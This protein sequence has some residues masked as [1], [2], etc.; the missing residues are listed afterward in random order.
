MKIIKIWF[1]ILII[2]FSISYSF[3]LSY[4]LKEISKPWCRFLSWA[5]HNQ[6]C[7]IELP[8]IEN[9]DYKK[10]IN[11]INYRIIYSVL[12]TSTY[13]NWWDVWY[14]SHIWVD[15][16]SAKWTP[17]YSIFDWEIVVAKNLAWRWNTVVIKHF[18]NWKYIYSVYAH[19]SKIEINLWD[20]I[21]EWEKIGEIWSTWNSIWN[22]LHFQIDINDIWSHPYYYSSCKW[23]VESVVNS[24]ECKQLVEKNTIDPILF[25]ESNWKF[26]SESNN[27]SQ[28]ILDEK[29]INP[30]DIK[31]KRQD[32]EKAET[33][34][35]LKLYKINL[36]SF[37]PQ[38][39][40]NPNEIWYIWVSFYDNIKKKE[41][42]WV[43][44]SYLE[45]EFDSWQVDIFPQKIKLIENWIRKIKI[46]AKKTW[47]SSINFK[48][49]WITVLKYNLII[50]DN[51][52]N[53]QAS[54][55]NLQ[56]FW[57]NIVWTDNIWIWIMKDWLNFN[58][59]WIKYW[60]DF[61]IEVNWEAQICILRITKKSQLKNLSKL[62]CSKNKYWKELY[63]NY[64]DTYK[65]ILFFK[66][67]FKSKNDIEFKLYNTKNNRLLFTKKISWISYPLDLLSNDPYYKYII[68]S[69]EWWYI[70]NFKK[71]YFAPNFD[72]EKKDFEKLIKINYNKTVSIKSKYITRLEFIKKLYEIDEK[73]N[74]KYDWKWFKDINDSDKK[75][76][77][78]LLKNNIK[79]LDNYWERYFQ[80][81]KNITRKEVAYLIY[82]L[83]KK[84]KNN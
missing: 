68:Q 61:K 73:L 19:L 49:L 33:E 30:I 57:S 38:N 69:L 8:R 46:T 15:I 66:Y 21:K 50:K 7:I 35:F 40:I 13:E 36:N 6:N 1:W 10:Y 72:F 17:V 26:L 27:N 84:E 41:F 75:Y 48:L 60:W 81:N 20:K 78:Y 47:S 43:L 56:L 23:N 52:L 12:W 55:W 77:N 63:F 5:E 79:F 4:P 11:D 45:I 9:A 59:V 16:A 53:Y 71:K 67:Y 14:W 18:I 64:F 22:H 28:E 51:N 32:I 37:I 54:K 34:M 2:I 83:F 62:D 3:W 74:T 58:L 80:P 25:I 42:N 82:Q 39:V 76:L 24:D 29:K 31:I 44:P 70:R 65:W